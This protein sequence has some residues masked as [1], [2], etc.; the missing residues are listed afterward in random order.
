MLLSVGEGMEH[1]LYI[2]QV[3]LEGNSMQEFYMYMYMY[4]CMCMY[5]CIYLCMYMCMYLMHDMMMST[6]LL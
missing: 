1:Y 3:D 4:M 2:A 5:M 6:Y